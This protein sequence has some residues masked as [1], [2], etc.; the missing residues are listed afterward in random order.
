MTFVLIGAGGHARSV[1]E[2]ISSSRGT[3]TA[4]ADP[5]E[6]LWLDAPRVDETRIGDHVPPAS[7]AMGIGGVDPDGL[8]DRLQLL[9]RFLDQGLAAAPILHRAAVVS[10]S[11]EIG[12][13]SIVFAGAIIQPGA[14]VGRGVIVNSGAIVEHDAQI[15]AGSH[16]AP[17]AIVLGGCRVGECCMIGAGAV[18]LQGASVGD[19]VLVPATSR[20][21]G[22]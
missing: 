8:S 16:I 9:D 22:S 2:V 18:V 12:Q 21:P 4:Y 3:I 13:G 7:I 17:G 15:G 11:A 19:R 20:H 10:G 5:H 14:I 6:S 1:S